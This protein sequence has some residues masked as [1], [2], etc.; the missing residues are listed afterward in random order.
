MSSAITQNTPLSSAEFANYLLQQKL[1][2][3]KLNQSDP[4]QK[5][6][7]L[8]SDR[9]LQ[10]PFPT[11]RQEEWKY[12]D[13]SGLL[14]F[15]WQL[16]LAPETD[17]ENARLKQIISA[18]ILPE[19]T[20]SNLVFVNGVFSPNFS[21]LKNLPKAMIASGINLKLDRDRY[22]HICQKYLITDSEDYFA[23]LN[24][25]CFRDLALVDIP[26]NTKIETPLQIL[27]VHHFGEK[28]AIA[29]NR[30]LVIVGANSE[31]NLV[32]TEVGVDDRPYFANSVTQIWLEGNAKLDHTHL[33]QQGNQAFDLASTQIFQAKESS[34]TGQFISLG[35]KLSRHYLHIQQ[36]G[37]AANTE[38]D[39]LAMIDQ[40]QLADT[41][42]IIAH[43]A[44]NGISR[45]MHKCVIS[46]RAHAVFSGKIEVAKAAQMTKSEQLSR[47]LLLS[48]QARVETQPQ[49]EILADN[50]KCAHGATVSQLESEEIFYLQSRGIA[51]DKAV[52]LLT[53]G[54]AAEVIVKIP[55]FSLRDRLSKYVLGLVQANSE[56]L[57]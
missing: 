47:N 28:V 37:E 6:Q 45:Q 55:I 1:I 7:N 20:E 51:V 27:F 32:Q 10:I 22:H 35:A 8:N 9:I 11:L 34:Y 12:T 31:I 25:A 43:K 40:Q 29:H 41:H 57:T 2:E 17:I 53:Y 54:F 13:V 4:I 14:S 48:P 38:V 44:A 33:Q 18:N 3:G 30:S 19:S 39:G 5:F 16:G 42:S 50:V 49:L 23:T 36:Q 15:Y 21:T 24:S 26:A 46:D 52:N 56:R